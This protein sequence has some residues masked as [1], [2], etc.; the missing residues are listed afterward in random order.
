MKLSSLDLSRSAD[1]GVSIGKRRYAAV[2]HSLASFAP[3]ALEY[4]NGR[5]QM[6]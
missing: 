3:R 4:S 1:R 6:R 5:A 2:V